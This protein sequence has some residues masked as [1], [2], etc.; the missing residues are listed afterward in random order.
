MLDQVQ[1]RQADFNN[2]AHVSNS[3]VLSRLKLV[4][5]KLFAWVYGVVGRR[6]DLVLVNSSWTLGHILSIWKSPECTF[7][8]NP[9]CDV[10]EFLTIPL[11]VRQVDDSRLHKIVSVAQ[12]RPEK[13]HRL[14]L[15]AFEKFLASVPPERRSLF[16]LLLVGGCRN[17]EDTARVG[18]LKRFVKEHNIAENVEFRLNVSFSELKNHLMEADVGLHTMWNEH[19]GI[20]LCF[21]I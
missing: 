3:A 8:V 17:E 6:S 7:I 5:Y 12:F 18:I 16:Q 4:Y 20:G 14:Q 10:A 13:N 15:L 1:R 9:P 21:F 11:D 19:F 2:P